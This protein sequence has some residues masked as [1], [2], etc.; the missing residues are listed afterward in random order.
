[1]IARRLITGSNRRLRRGSGLLVALG[2]ATGCLTAQPVGAQQTGEPRS[3]PQRP[4]QSRD[5]TDRLELR[6]PQRLPSFEAL[7]RRMDQAAMIDLRRR[8][9]ELDK[10]LSLGSLS[11][12]ESL[13]NSLEQHSRLLRELQPRRI[14]LAQLK[15]DWDEVLALTRSGLDEQPDN[16]TLWRVR[17]EAMLATG[18]ADSVRFNLDRFLATSPNLSSATVA[19]VQM[20]QGAGWHRASVALID[21]MRI[22][23]GQVRY[24]ARARAVA[25]LQVDRQGEAAS[26]VDIELR[27][28]PYNLPLL[29]GALLDGVYDPRRHVRFGEDLVDRADSRD[30]PA[31]LRLLAANLL[32]ADGRADRALQLVEPLIDSSRDA[33]IVM[34]N[35]ATLALEL[36]LLESDA[37][38]KATVDYLLGA[39]SGLLEARTVAPDQRRRA[40]DAL[41]GTCEQ[42]LRFGALGDDPE[43]SVERFGELL[44]QVRKVNPRSEALYSAQIHLA[45]YTRDVLREPAQAAR[46]LEHML[47]DLDLPTEG[48]AL[49]RL[50]LGEC[51]LAA[52]DTARG[53]AVLTRL[54]RDP[55][56]RA[57]GGHAHYHLARLDLAEGHFATAR[58]RFAVVAIDH[59]TAPYANE[60]LEMGLA[61]A[62]EMENPSGGPNVLALY[63]RSVYHDLIGDEAGRIQALESF[64]A[65]APALVDLEEPQHLLERAKYE[66]AGLYAGQ[67]R[68]EE[69]LR[70]WRRVVTDHPDG[71]FAAASL[72]HRADLLASEGRIEGARQEL[73]LLLA[74]YPDYLFID[75][76]R[77]RRREWQ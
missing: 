16:P 41:A 71:R 74:Q 29:R 25:L 57:A 32:L 58:D 59:P 62:E 51:Y 15:G 10:L 67:G 12:A 46:R 33:H 73:D 45:G 17:T 50:T 56:F 27:S 28:Q 48:V 30:A 47:L 9:I 4:P 76:V 6:Q 18:R 64:L 2:L 20:L 19:G 21:S 31:S 36:E 60:A 23:L 38:R 53:R 40:A 77:D 42:A 69:A 13:L 63:A 65:E 7:E 5:N 11:R 43:E 68:A 44:Q 24:L 72:Q 52:G 1:M 26:E 70:L 54:G 39:L 3:Q 61:I 14:R 55:D 49:V 35:T 8:L 34:Q 37:R 75:D 66:L 22:R